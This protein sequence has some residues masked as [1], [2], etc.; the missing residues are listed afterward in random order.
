MSPLRVT[1]KEM[2]PTF[3]SF[4]TQ[5]H[6]RPF[7]PPPPPRLSNSLAPVKLCAIAGG[8]YVVSG[9]LEM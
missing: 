6:P 5:V 1:I 3:A 7:A 4:M 9:Q 2:R 8:V